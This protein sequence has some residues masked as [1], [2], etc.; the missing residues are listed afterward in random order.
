[1]SFKLDG[2]PPVSA[3]CLESTAKIKLKQKLI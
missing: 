2:I 1:M 3:Q